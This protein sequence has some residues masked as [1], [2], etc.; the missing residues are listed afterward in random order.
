MT[1][2]FVMETEEGWAM[3]SEVVEIARIA[4]MRPHEVMK[5]LDKLRQDT[6]LIRTAKAWEQR[7]IE[8][9]L[10]PEA[11]ALE[12]LIATVIVRLR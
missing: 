2:P 10:S 7:Q 9:M 5:D 11:D 12:R 8:L 6:T 4:G 1:S 3:A